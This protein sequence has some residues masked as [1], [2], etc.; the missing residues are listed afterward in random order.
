MKKVLVVFVIFLLFCLSI[1]ISYADGCPIAPLV[2]TAENAGVNSVL[3]SPSFSAPSAL[4]I[5]F[6]AYSQKAIL[7]EDFDL[8]AKDFSM[9]EELRDYS[10][11]IIK[12]LWN[13]RF[14]II[15]YLTPDR[16]Y[17]Q[18]VS[19]VVF[20]KSIQIGNQIIQTNQDMFDYAY[21]KLMR[22]A[23]VYDEGSISSFDEYAVWKRSDTGVYIVLE[24]NNLES[25]F[26][27]GN[28]YFHFIQPK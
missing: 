21:E 11:G 24:S 5:L 28:L 16:E 12:Y 7:I 10:L 22:I 13:S 1:G 20:G 25:P 3:V 23:D 17:V 8:I 18:E 15:A 2:T 9:S 19:L 26:I 27:E 4:G 6:V 14:E